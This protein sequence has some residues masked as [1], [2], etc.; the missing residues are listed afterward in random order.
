MRSFTSIP[1]VPTGK[2]IKERFTTVKAWE[3]PKQKSALAPEHV[4]TNEDMDPVKKEN[5]TWTLW[6]WMAY[7]ATDTITLGTWETASSILAVGLT[8]REAIPIT[9]TEKCKR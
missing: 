1:Y 4:W 6:T 2:Q 7:W 3:L 8:W 9:K 5:Q